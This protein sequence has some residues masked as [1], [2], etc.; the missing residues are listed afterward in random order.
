M[1][2]SNQPLGALNDDLLNRLSKLK[3]AVVGHQEWVT[4]L[5]VN[6]LPKPGV[7]SRSSR[8][9][10]EP[11]G[12]GAVVAVQLARLTAQRVPFFTAL[13]RDDI[14][15]RSVQRLQ[16]LGVDPHVA[17][18]NSTS[19]RGI[20]LVDATGDRAITV[21][22]DRLT[23]QSTDDLPWDMLSSCDGVFVSATDAKGL[24][25]ARSAHVLTATPRLGQSILQEAAVELNALIGSGLDPDEHINQEALS[26]QPRLTIAT[27]GAKG[28][29]MHPGGRYEANTPRA[30]LIESYGCGDNFAAG[31]TAGL[32]AG[33]SAREAVQLGAVCGSECATRFGPY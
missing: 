10:E 2:P 31:V 22:G 6:Q 32:A 9:I 14:A 19:R 30:A 18:R 16:A 15:K 33:L 27:E 13:G 28:G 5:S 1:V 23:P 21:I 4:F 12:A 17:W 26:P 3:L 7:I 8:S 25:L 11:A 20:S 29:I 24:T